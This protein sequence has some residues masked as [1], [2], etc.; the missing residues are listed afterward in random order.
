MDVKQEDFSKRVQLF[1][2]DSKQRYAYFSSKQY[3]HLV[4][5]NLEDI[6]LAST[7]S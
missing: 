5:N 6:I 4:L 2:K 7:V 3:V 1:D